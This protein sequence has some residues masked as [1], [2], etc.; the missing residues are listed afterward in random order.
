MSAAANDG[1]PAAGRIPDFYI[2][3]HAKC[4][5]TALYEMLSR[6]PEIFMPSYEKGA[7]KEPWYFSRDNP[8]PQTS[9]ERNIA[10]TGRK[11]QTLEQYLSLFAGA[12][13]GQLVGEA[14][15]SYLWSTS[16]AARIAQARPDA[17]IVGIIRE[18]ASFLRSLHLQLLQNHH[19]VETDFRKAVELDGPR[20]ESRMIPERSYWPQALI[21]SDRVRYVEQ[22][23]RYRA[24][25]P[26]EQMLILIYDDFRDDNRGTVEEVLRFLG[27]DSEH[28]VE[29]AHVNPTV[30]I[31]SMR[32]DTLRR[33]LTRGER[34]LLRA[35]RD[36]GKTVTTHGMRKRLYYPLMRR[37]SFGAPPPEDEKFMLELR[38]RFKGEVVALSEYLGRDLVSLWG[39]DAID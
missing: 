17:K 22:L 35:V 32:A 13:E 19:E 20:R 12:R 37:A 11:S 15:T 8:H 23:E 24:V 26:S 33:E 34:P 3:G 1:A 31:R 36:V 4:G 2:V 6:H 5:T 27:V 29:A 38:R 7:G 14:S 9:G 39:Y 21:Y 30:G 25:F 16:A 28:T 10:Y 18:P